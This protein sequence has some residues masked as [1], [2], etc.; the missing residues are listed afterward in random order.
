MCK[1]A[2]LEVVITQDHRAMGCDTPSLVF[3]LLTEIRRG[4]HY[5]G[6]GLGDGTDGEKQ[7]LTGF[8]D[9]TARF[10]SVMGLVIAEKDGS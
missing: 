2:G 1:F 3:P 8:E 9:F 10:T 6:G 7:R 5:R 4:H